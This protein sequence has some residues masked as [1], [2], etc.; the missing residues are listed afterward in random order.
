M[1]SLREIRIFSLFLFLITISYG[2]GNKP[3]VLPDKARLYAEG[4]TGNQSF[5]NYKT[6][7]FS[8][9]LTPVYKLINDAFKSTGS[10]RGGKLV[11]Y[12]NGSIMSFTRTVGNISLLV[13]VNCSKEEQQYVTPMSLR[14]TTMIDLLKK[15]PEE[16][17]VTI[18]L[19]PYGYAL[20]LTE[21]LL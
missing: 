5:F 21:I 10:V 15:A 6:L 9:K 12:S 3:S 7:S 17:P 18:T 16:L 11:D 4:L 14:Y 2:C 8:D 20:Y 1:T 13:I 19:P